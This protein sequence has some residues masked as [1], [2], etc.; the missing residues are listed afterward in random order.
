MCSEPDFFSSL[1]IRNI[2]SFFNI[3]SHERMMQLKALN[4][5]VCLCVAQILIECLLGTKLCAGPSCGEKDLVSRSLQSEGRMG[6][7]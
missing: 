6:A 5:G 4:S 7:K 3:H 2:F 1:F